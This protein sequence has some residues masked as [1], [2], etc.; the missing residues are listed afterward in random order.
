MIRPVQRREALPSQPKDQPLQ[1]APRL[2]R[3]GSANDSYSSLLVYPI[4]QSPSRALRETRHAAHRRPES[5]P[6]APSTIIGLQTAPSMWRIKLGSQP[7][8][9]SPPFDPIVEA[10]LESLPLPTTKPSS[11]EL[12]QW[13]LSN[14]HGL[15]WSVFVICIVLRTAS[16]TIALPVTGV[17]A[18]VIAGRRGPFNAIE[19]LLPVVIVV[20]SYS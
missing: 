18:S 5:R 20:R 8:R 10:W 7:S 9:P 6:S 15:G 11:K 1:V 14:Y 17:I 16:L 3:Y 2:W 4:S 19:R 12:K 13:R